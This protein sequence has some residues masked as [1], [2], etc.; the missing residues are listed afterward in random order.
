MISPEAC[1]LLIS[2]EYIYTFDYDLILKGLFSSHAK[3]GYIIYIFI[4]L[5][6]CILNYGGSQRKHDSTKCT[7]INNNTFKQFQLDSCIREN[8]NM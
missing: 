5:I 7:L 2:D 1:V 6:D 4:L 8:I 3:F